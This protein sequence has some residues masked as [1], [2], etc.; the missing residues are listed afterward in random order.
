LIALF[1]DF[2]AGQGDVPEGRK[3]YF[4]EISGVANDSRNHYVLVLKSSQVSFRK[5]YLIQHPSQIIPQPFI[6]FP[7][8]FFTY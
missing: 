7:L 8:M 2:L 4:L 6:S 3:P 5:G 1:G